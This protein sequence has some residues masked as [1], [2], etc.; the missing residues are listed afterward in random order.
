MIYKLC[1]L[2]TLL[3][4]IFIAWII[5][6]ANTGQSSIFFT[7]VAS[8]PYGDKI[9]HFC[10]FGLLTLGANFAFKLKQLHLFSLPVY[11]GSIVVFIFII[12]EELSQYFIPSRTLDITDLLADM[13]GI[14]IFNFITSYIAKYL[15]NVES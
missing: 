1:G 3:F 6:L 10:L 11:I 4:F 8:I 13:F 5:Y 12:F 2:L 9:G 15:H 14:I 7:L